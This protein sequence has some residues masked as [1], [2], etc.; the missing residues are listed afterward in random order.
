MNTPN[1]GLPAHEEYSAFKS[2]RNNSFCGECSIELTLKKVP[3]PMYHGKYLCDS[4]MNDIASL[5]GTE[6]ES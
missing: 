1:L 3:A 5:V 6:W 2:S 4:C